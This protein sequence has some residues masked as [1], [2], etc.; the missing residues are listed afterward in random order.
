[1]SLAGISWKCK[2][3]ACKQKD[4]VKYEIYSRVHQELNPMGPNSALLFALCRMPDKAD[5]VMVAAFKHPPFRHKY[6]PTQPEVVADA[7]HEHN[8]RVGSIVLF[9]ISALCHIS[10][11]GYLQSSIRQAVPTTLTS[12]VWRFQVDLFI[13]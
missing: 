12:D 6:Y 10:T 4:G 13:P 9:S 7:V 2:A 5:P 11:V 8:Y 1:M 3:P